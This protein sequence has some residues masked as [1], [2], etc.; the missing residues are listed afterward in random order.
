MQNTRTK[1]PASEGHWRLPSPPIVGEQH[2][3]SFGVATYIIDSRAKRSSRLR[4]IRMR[5]ITRMMVMMTRMVMRR[6]RMREEERMRRRC[7]DKNLRNPNLKGGEKY[8]IHKI[9]LQE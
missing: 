1:T 3:I 4:I 5:M 2:V 6:M 8:Q 7:L 9:K